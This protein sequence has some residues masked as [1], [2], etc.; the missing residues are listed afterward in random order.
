MF[1]I[2]SLENFIKAVSKASQD[3]TS[4]EKGTAPFAAFEKMVANLLS[5][6]SELTGE[7]VY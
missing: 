1:Q 2:S 4:V 7:E 5:L 6:R 3:L